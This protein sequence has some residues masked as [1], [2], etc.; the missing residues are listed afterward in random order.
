MDDRRQPTPA[1][2]DAVK[3]D[4]P[5]APPPRVCEDCRF[6]K[7]DYGMFCV[8]GWTGMGRDEGHCHVEPRRI[9]IQGQTPACRYGEK[10]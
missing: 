5:P 2:A 8:N 7:K 10:I 3:P 6:W 1:P 4:P 9:P